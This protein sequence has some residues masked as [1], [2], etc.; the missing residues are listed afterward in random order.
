LGAIGLLLAGAL[1]LAVSNSLFPVKDLL[2][3]E[4]N[5]GAVAPELQRS[6]SVGTDQYIDPR[7]T[8]SIIKAETDDVFAINKNQV[9]QM[10]REA[11]ALTGGL[12]DIISDGNT[13]VLKPN[14]VMTTF[15]GAELPT[16]ANG[17]VTDW[18]VAAA[19]AKMVREVNP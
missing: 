3:G 17:M 9:E 4:T 12:E 18:R 7:A 11:V 8:V 5:S 2:A 1:L 6:Y 19:V 15:R 16:E 13:V 14:F 10:V